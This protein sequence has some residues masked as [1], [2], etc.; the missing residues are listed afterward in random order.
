MGCKLKIFSSG[1]KENAYR[2]TDGEY[3]VGRSRSAQIK[4][5]EPDVSGKHL[6]LKVSGDKITAENLSSHGT[7]LENVSIESPV[8]VSSGQCL[9]LGKMIKIFIIDEALDIE[10][11]ITVAPA[12]D[13]T[14]ILDTAVK[15]KQAP[16][17][18]AREVTGRTIEIQIK[19][20]TAPPPPRTGPPPKAVQPVSAQPP[21]QPTATPQAMKTAAPPPQKTQQNT[22][23]PSADKTVPPPTSKP[24]SITHP[25]P[26]DIDKT[27]PPVHAQAH[28]IHKTEPPQYSNVTEAGNESLSEDDILKTNVLQTRVATAEEM[29]FLR[30]QEKKKTQGRYVWYALAA[31]GVIAIM[32]IIYQFRPPPPEQ[33][34]SWPRD[35]KGKALDKFIPLK[36]GDSYE[37]GKFSL[38]VPDVKGTVIKD[39]ADGM[40][41]STFVGRDKDVQLRVILSV[42]KSKQFLNEDRMTTF[43]NWMKEVS[44]SGGLWNFDPPSDL[45]FIGQNNGLPCLRVAYRREA[46]NKSWYGEALFFR[47]GDERI[48]RQAEIPTGERI[49]GERIVSGEVYLRLSPQWIT[50][51]WEGSPEQLRDGT[52]RDMLNEARL[53]LTKMS[54]ATWSK[55]YLLIRSVLIASTASGDNALVEEALAQLRVLRDRQRS[56]YNAQKLAYLRE[57]QL[58]NEAGMARIRESCKA[59]F[60]SEDDLRCLNIRR[61]KWE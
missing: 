5:E 49:R 38:L 21:P 26:H 44:A 6:L 4:V 18:P 57:K 35:S 48:V 28:D 42:K 3:I 13:V 12:A 50:D 41:V 40:E 53:L 24:V 2:L 15:N 43:R 27:V 37:T 23:S 17:P 58:K 59:V 11:A 30:L 55:T 32:F 39:S 54:P 36:N 61:N 20:Q 29:D 60:S 52:P 14:S 8:S 34:L 1:N 33:T 25:A 9:K 56:W 31:V 51:H 45:M 22:V 7:M 47:C 16:P 46:E 19:P 10:G